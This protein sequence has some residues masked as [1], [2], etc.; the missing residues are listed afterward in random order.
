MV[1]SRGSLEF[2]NEYN[3]A[4]ALEEKYSLMDKDTRFRYFMFGESIPSFELHRRDGSLNVTGT[5]PLFTLDK[6]DLEYVY[7]KYSKLKEVVLKS[8]IDSI[9]DRYKNI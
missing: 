6:E 1:N 5:C 8:E 4:I 3:K 2:C 9:T 7:E